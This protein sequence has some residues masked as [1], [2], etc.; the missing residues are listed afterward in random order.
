MIE[1]QII[2]F[3]CLFLPDTQMADL[4]KEQQL[5]RKACCAR[6]STHGS[7]S[8]DTVP[9]NILPP[10]CRSPAFLFQGKLP[11]GSPINHNGW[12]VRPTADNGEKGTGGATVLPG[13][14]PL[15]AIRGF[16]LGYAGRDADRLLS[17]ATGAGFSAFSVNVWYWATMKVSIEFERG[18]LYSAA[19]EC[20]AAEWH[21]A[22]R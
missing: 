15:P 9:F 18:R 1:K 5:L 21:K 10:F 3:D 2:T 8:A 14:P 6:D 13:Y 7:A 11:V 17:E 20:G 16:I 4:E 22:T 19:Y 12:I